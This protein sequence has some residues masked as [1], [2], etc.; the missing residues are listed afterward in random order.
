VFGAAVMIAG[1]G[2][3]QQ[4]RTE[5]PAHTDTTAAP[6]DTVPAPP[7]PPPVSYSRAALRSDRAIRA[8]R[9]SLD[10]DTWMMVLKVNRVDSMHVRVGDTLSVPSAHDLLA[11]SP[12]PTVFDAVRDTSKLLLVSRRVQAFGV[13]EAG[14]LVRWGPVS[15]GR[16]DKPTPVGLYHTNW[17]DQHRLST[18]D[19]TWVLK[20]YLNLDNFQGVSL[21]EF[22][23]PGR[24]ASHS[25][26]RLLEE[27]ARW[28]FGWAES[29]QLG[30]DRR[31]ALRNGT[32]VVVFGDW[33]WGRRAPWKQLPED[34]HATQLTEEEMSDALRILHEAVKPDYSIGAGVPSEGATRPAPTP[35]GRP[36][37]PPGSGIEMPAS[38]DS[39]DSLRPPARPDTGGR[40][41]IK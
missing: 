10:G 40:S 41:S 17:K 6:I 26:I 22:E 28:L 15:T 29:W 11:L 36:A 5:A 16:K 19:S 18:I 32:P 23:L 9:D 31:I 39:Y 2:G 33:A 20:W 8:F 3:G 25:C 21:H 13:Y 12:F 35:P 7:L 30:S 37:R 4:S 14:R 27:D 34:P 24:P 38:P 1:C